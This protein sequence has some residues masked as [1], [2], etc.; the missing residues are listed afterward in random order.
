MAY[1]LK[2]S[3]CDPLRNRKLKTENAIEGKVEE[4]ILDTGPNCIEAYGAL[5]HTPHTP[6]RR[7][8]NFESG[9]T[10]FWKSKMARKRRS[11]RL[12]DAGG[13]QK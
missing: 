10:K 1:G 2:V 5:P 11:S 8:N 9:G 6:H 7:R 3:S 12:R 13:C 4:N